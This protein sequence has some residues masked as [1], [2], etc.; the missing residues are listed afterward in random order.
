ME[1][2]DGRLVIGVLRHEFAVDGKVKHF[3]THLAYR[4]LQVLL[5]CLQIIYQRKPLL[6]LRY[7]TPLLRE[8]RE[9]NEGICYNFF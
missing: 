2:V 8:R 5:V 6:H 4:R 9:G 3:G 1:K 7:D